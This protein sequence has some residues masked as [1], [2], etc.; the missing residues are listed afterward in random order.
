VKF[1]RIGL[2]L[3]LHWYLLVH[4]ANTSRLS[5]LGTKSLCCLRQTLCC[6]LRPRG[7]VL[8]WC[9]GNNPPFVVCGIRLIGLPALSCREVISA[10]LPFPLAGQPFHRSNPAHSTSP[11]SHCQVRADVSFLLRCQGSR[12]VPYKGTA[13]LHVGGVSSDPSQFRVRKPHTNS[14]A[15]TDGTSASNNYF[16]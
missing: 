16:H 3:I 9:V 1:L 15:H 2:L 4:R 13:I 10:C 6:L 14:P 8:G 5:M 7:F 12:L 11:M